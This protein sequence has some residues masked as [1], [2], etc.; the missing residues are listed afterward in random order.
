MWSG[1]Y[2]EVR[3]DGQ[4]EYAARTGDMTAVVIVAFDDDGRVVLVE[5]Q[6]L[7]IGRRSLELPAGLVGDDAAGERVEDAAA[8]E[9]EEETGYRAARIESLGEFF[10]SPGM[11]SEAFTLVRAT[12]LTRVGEGGGVEAEDIAVHLVP[13]ADIARF[14]AERRA[15]GVGIDAKVLLLLGPVLL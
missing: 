14:V 12:G 10:S 2:L 13:R 15:A 1:R 6:R 5:Q 9:L 4:W 7:P 11:T 3:R 8:R